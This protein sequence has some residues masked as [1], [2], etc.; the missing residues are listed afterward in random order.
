MTT[1]VVA[2]M[3][4]RATINSTDVDSIP[5]AESGEQKCLNENGASKHWVPRFLLPILVC[6]G[7]SVKLKK[8]TSCIDHLFLNTFFC[9]ILYIPICISYVL[10]D[11]VIVITPVSLYKQFS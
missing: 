7:Y 5:T 6:A 10:L 8:T 1:V 2:Q 3:H 11:K 4:K 9:L